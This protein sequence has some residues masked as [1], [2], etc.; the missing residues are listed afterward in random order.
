M[1]KERERERQRQ[2]DRQTDRYSEHCA[3]DWYFLFSNS[4][5]SHHGC[6]SRILGHALISLVTALACLSATT[7][8]AGRREQCKSYPFY[9]MCNGA[10]LSDF[11]CMKLFEETWQPVVL[12]LL[13]FCVLEREHGH[14]RVETLERNKWNQRIKERN[15]SFEVFLYLYE[16]LSIHWY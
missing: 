10:R 7:V 16:W 11:S 2:T 3:H 12:I 15:I 9:P 1:N 13:I 8:Y 6:K 4:C 14:E 5:G